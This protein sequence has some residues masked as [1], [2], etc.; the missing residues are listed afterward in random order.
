MKIHRAED[1]KKKEKQLQCQEAKK[2]RD[3]KEAEFLSKVR[4]SR[5]FI[6]ND[7]EKVEVMLPSP[8][9][10]GSVKTKSDLTEGISSSVLQTTFPSFRTDQVIARPKSQSKVSISPALTDSTR[11]GVIIA[12]MNWRIDFCILSCFQ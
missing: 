1:D 6:M 9:S 10:V 4:E 8:Q 7:N 11:L 12:A 5:S 2:I 3:A